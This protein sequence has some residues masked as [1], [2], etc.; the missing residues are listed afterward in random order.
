MARVLALREDMPGDQLAD[1]ARVVGD[2][3][4]LALPTESFYAL[5]AS[6]VDARAVRRVRAIKG[7]ADGKPI[8]VLIGDRAQ[9]EALASEVSPAAR[10]LM[11]RFWPG[12]LTL[13]VRAALH[14]PEELTAGTGTVG[15][16]HVGHRALARVLRH[17]GPLTGTSANRAG[18]PPAQSAEDVQALLGS[19]LDLILDG[20]PTAGGMPS[21][22]VETV[23]GLRLLREGPIVRSQLESA[24]ADIGLALSP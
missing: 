16:R 5:G 20:G 12:P 14:L 8:L 17:A 23:G 6:P 19:E 11:D 3:G 4:V 24:L 1:V 18:H 9:I 21:T 22:V 7:R 13:I 15:I 10:W 2:H